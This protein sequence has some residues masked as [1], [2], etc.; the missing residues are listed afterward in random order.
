LNYGLSFG[1]P[2]NDVY[3]LVGTK[4]NLDENVEKIEILEDDDL[5]VL[6]KLLPDGNINELCYK[7]ASPVEVVVSLVEVVASPV[8]VVVSLVEVVA[9]PVE[10]VVNPVDEVESS[11]YNVEA[12]SYFFE[13]K[14]SNYLNF[15]L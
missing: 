8:E 13:I 2:Y 4:A 6:E 1:E 3:D 14:I 15:L 7:V 9:S 5:E 12:L 11:V 10:V